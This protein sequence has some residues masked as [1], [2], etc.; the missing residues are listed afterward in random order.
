[1]LGTT[2][3]LRVSVKREKQ[4]KIL[5]HSYEALGEG[6]VVPKRM[7]D[8]TESPEIAKNTHLWM[9]TN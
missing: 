3:K 9:G 2:E 8:F 5:K 1:M 4:G 7:I 6:L